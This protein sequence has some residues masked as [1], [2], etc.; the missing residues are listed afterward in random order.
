MENPVSCPFHCTRTATV[1]GGVR[2]VCAA[3]AGSTLFR[4]WKHK[5]H[6]RRPESTPEVLFFRTD[7]GA[8]GWGTGNP[9]PVQL[10]CKR[11]AH[12][13]ATG[14]A[15]HPALHPASPHSGLGTLSEGWARAAAPVKKPGKT[16]NPSGIGADMRP[17]SRGRFGAAK[18][19]IARLSTL[20]VYTR[21]IGLGLAQSYHWCP[22]P[23]QSHQTIGLSPSRIGLRLN[24][25][26][27]RCALRNKAILKRLGTPD[28]YPR[29][30]IGLAAEV[31]TCAATLGWDGVL[32]ELCER[33]IKLSNEER[34]IHTTM[35]KNRFRLVHLQSQE[36]IDSW[37]EFCAAQTEPAIKIS[38]QDWCMH[39]LANPWILPSINNFP[40][41]ISADNWDITPNYTNYIETA[42]AGRNAETAI[43]VGLTGLELE[44]YP[45]TLLMDSSGTAQDLLND[46]MISG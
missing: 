7:P 28:H 25:H 20:R 5:A 29:P 23:T 26:Q 42:H 34:Y 43:G 30:C 18:R 41:K 36:E 32:N 13:S 8:G 37:H 44:A 19:W 17:A 11:G 33:E 39:K 40:S 2:A 22:N 15:S 10:P 14:Y 21:R 38:G 27:F 35:D 4:V 24:Q 3:T 6:S 46:D 16:V 31:V 12:G 1:C 45:T 9:Q